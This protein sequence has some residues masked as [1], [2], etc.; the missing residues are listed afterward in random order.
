[1]GLSVDYPSICYYFLPS[2]SIGNMENQVGD[3]FKKYKEAVVKIMSSNNRS[4]ILGDGTG[5]MITM[6]DKVYIITNCHIIFD[7]DTQHP[8]ENIF[9]NVDNFKGRG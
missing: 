1:M 3:L 5:F 7:I 8:H 9:T 4:N 6:C 2:L